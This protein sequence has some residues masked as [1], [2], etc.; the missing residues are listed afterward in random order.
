MQGFFQQYLLLYRPLISKLNEILSEFDLSYSLWQIIF[1]VKNNGSTSLVE[2]SNHFNVE[3][4]TVTRTVRRLEEKRIVQVIPSNDKR[5]KI[6]KLTETGED[7]YQTCRGK[8][9]DLEN[10]IMG[11]IPEIEQYAAFH[12]LHKIR[13]NIINDEGS[14]N[15]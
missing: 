4:P 2:I 6:I 8:I 5:E 15:D 11:E 13:E 12:M 10:M 9:T 3:K 7:I 14:K 1:F